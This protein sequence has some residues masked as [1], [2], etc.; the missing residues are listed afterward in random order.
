[1][2]KVPG[3]S[4]GDGRTFLPFFGK[5]GGNFELSMS[6]LEIP[7]SSCEKFFFLCSTNVSPSLVLRKKGTLEFENGIEHRCQ[8]R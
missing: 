2:L 5:I 6:T 7:S 8:L 1:M 3:S 4:S